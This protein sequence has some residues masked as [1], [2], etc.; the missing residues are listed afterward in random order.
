MLAGLARLARSG[1][2]LRVFRSTAPITAGIDLRPP[3]GV[4]VSGQVL[5]LDGRTQCWPA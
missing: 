5:R 4:F 3:L 2:S 1:P